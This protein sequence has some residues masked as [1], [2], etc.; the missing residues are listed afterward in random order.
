M[1]WAIFSS[2]WASFWPHPWDQSHTWESGHHSR[3]TLSQG[4]NYWDLVWSLH[5]CLQLSVRLVSLRLSLSLV[6]RILLACLISIASEYFGSLDMMRF[7]LVHSW[8]A[9]SPYLVLMYVA[10]FS[11]NMQSMS[12]SLSLFPE[13]MVKRW[14]S[15]SLQTLSSVP[16]WACLVKSCFYWRDLLGQL[17]HL[18]HRIL[19]DRCLFLEPSRG[20][21]SRILFWLPHCAGD[22]T[23]NSCGLRD[24][25]EELDLVQFVTFLMIVLIERHPPE[26]VLQVG[27]VNY[28]SLFFSIHAYSHL[29]VIPQIMVWVWSMGKLLMQLDGLLSRATTHFYFD[30][31][32]LVT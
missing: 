27:Q 12:P 5:N 24:V 28:F 22:I 19:H 30:I 9:S 32:N 13:P 18:L 29:F 4:C 17:F 6:G 15:S 8:A 7:S 26:S 1:L 31:A 11:L 20:G 21:I 23:T 16:S 14:P 2:L 25:L 3:A 10:I